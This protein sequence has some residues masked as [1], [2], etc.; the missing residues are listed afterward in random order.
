[1]AR[2]PGLNEF[3][4]GPFL[5][6][7]GP[8]A[9]ASASILLPD[10]DAL[11][12]WANRPLAKARWWLLAY[13][14]GSPTDYQGGLPQKDTDG[15]HLLPRAAR[16][17][18]IPSSPPWGCRGHNGDFGPQRFRTALSSSLGRS[19]KRRPLTSSRGAAATDCSVLLRAKG[20]VFP[21]PPPPCGR[22]D[23]RL[24]P[25]FLSSGIDL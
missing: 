7:Y 15:S 21:L 6:D 23:G 2:P 10:A 20:S 18:G 25:P 12:I 14:G 3:L 22:A 4:R 5:P 1:M 13:R 19:D 24:P 8:V 16:T 9:K 11:S 17:S